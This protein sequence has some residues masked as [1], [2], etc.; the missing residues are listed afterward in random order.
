MMLAGSGPSS[1]TPTPFNSFT[2]SGAYQLENNG[3]TLDVGTG[4]E[5]EYHIDVS[6]LSVNLSCAKNFTLDLNAVRVELLRNGCARIVGTARDPAEQAAQEQA[7]AS[8]LGIW[9]PSAS[10]SPTATAG[11]SSPTATAGE[12]H[13][14]IANFFH[15]I[16]T[17]KLV[18]FSTGLAILGSPLLLMFLAW[19]VRL[20]HKRKVNIIIAGVSAA[21]KTALWTRWR[22]QYD[23]NPQP[24]T[25][26]AVARL[27]PVELR[28]WTLQPKVIDTPGTQPEH[29]L[30]EILRPKGF[31]GA[32]AKSRTKHVLVYVVSP[33]SQQSAAPSGPFDAIYIAKQEGHASSLPLALVRQ[34]D[35][36]IKLEPRHHV[37][38]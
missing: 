13:S 19:I 36:R 30:A 20:A 27:E 1:S 34:H 33:C 37:R 17:H 10:S 9:A 26:R 35:P 12:R 16:N 22:E 31:R 2:F 23:P 14:W 24:S 28:K 3:N 25:S 21:G 15:W 38:I 5:V 8:H 4:N 11:E 6:G 29:M 18:S 7:K 32:I